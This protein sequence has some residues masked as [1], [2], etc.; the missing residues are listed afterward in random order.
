MATCTESIASMPGYSSLTEIIPNTVTPFT[1]TAVNNRLFRLECPEFQTVKFNVSVNAPGATTITV[2]RWLEG[3]A[4]PIGS[5]NITTPTAVAYIDFQIGTYIVCV[6]PTGF[7]QQTGHLIAEFTGYSLEARLVSDHATGESMDVILSGP[8]TPPRECSEALFFEIVD[9]ELPPGLQMNPFGI[10]TGW[11]PN[12]DCLEDRW[13]PAVN[14]YYDENDGTTWP[15]G[16]E[17]RFQV[18]V[19]IDGQPESTNDI[20][21][22]CVRIHNNWSYDAQRFLAEAPFENITEV[23]VVDPPTTLPTICQPCK[24]FEEEARFVPQKIKD[25]EC[26]PCQ[27]NQ[28]TS[29]ELIPIPLDLCHI[30]STEFLEWYV[31]NGDDSGNPHIE[32]FKRDLE[33]SPAFTVL[34]ERAGYIEPDPLTPTQR[35]REFIV[36]QNYQNFLQLA[37]I[38]LADGHDEEAKSKVREW[39]IIENQALPTQASG[40]AG[41]GMEFRLK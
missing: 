22:F 19:W 11:L 35:E 3:V 29:I 33:N 24:Q 6:R 30:P 7:A 8:P 4:S 26:L 38:K 15:W 17:W 1:V 21:W 36:V 37:A 34:R 20:E 39:Q 5:I 31:R 41:E 28:S 32:K 40:Y 13:S 16:R 10:I 9:G 25:T 18:K 12:L 23:R 27:N 2:Y 14:W